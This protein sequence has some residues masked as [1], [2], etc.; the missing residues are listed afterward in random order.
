[1]GSYWSKEHTVGKT[2]GNVRDSK[3]REQSTEHLPVSQEKDVVHTDGRDLLSRTDE[4]SRILR[5]TDFETLPQILHV[6]S[7]EIVD[8]GEVQS[9]NYDDDGHGFDD[10]RTVRKMCSTDLKTKSTC[11]QDS[12]VNVTVHSVVSNKNRFALSSDTPVSLLNPCTSSDCSDKT[13]T[14]SPDSVAAV[15]QDKITENEVQ[16]VYLQTGEHKLY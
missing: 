5:Q 1:M 15:C 7:D 11:D 12:A 13:V 16:L 9:D 4:P 6:R 14:V 3:L 8:E 10:E 2:G